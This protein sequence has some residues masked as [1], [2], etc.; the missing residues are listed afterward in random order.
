MEAIGPDKATLREKITEVQTRL[1][2]ALADS[3]A[4]PDALDWRVEFG[5]VFSQRGGF[6]VAVANPPYIQLERNNGELRMLY[7]D[8][9]YDTLA[10]RG[11]IYQLFYER[12]C[13]VLLSERGLLAYITSNSWL[14]AEYGK[15]TRRFFSENHSP[16]RLLELGKDVFESAI[17]DSGVL[18]LRTGGR[19]GAF[20]AVDM[21]RLPNSSFP[22]DESLWGQVRPDAAKH[23]GA[24]CHALDQSMSCDKILTCEGHL[25]ETGPSRSTTWCH[26]R[27]Q[28]GLR[29]RR[30]D[31]GRAG[32]RRPQSL[33]IHHKT[34]TPRPRHSALPCEM[35]R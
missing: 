19:N 22:P 28:P 3:P 21:D 35:G 34:D 31:Q 16:L 20:P 10:S 24:S 26:H 30:H 12:G 27:L 5:E 15:S 33:P 14:K 2:A 29:H 9:G 25:S 18:M 8:I 13:Q 17:V 4:P 11:D 1:T 7:K 6:D 32:V 23:P